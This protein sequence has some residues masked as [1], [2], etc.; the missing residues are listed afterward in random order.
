[1]ETKQERLERQ[2]KAWKKMLK[3]IAYQNEGEI[4]LKAL[5]NS[6]MQRLISR[7]VY[8]VS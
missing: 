1:M 8:Q 6:N 3:D 2:N 7:G 4:F 5:N